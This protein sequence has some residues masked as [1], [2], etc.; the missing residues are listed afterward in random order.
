[1]FYPACLLDPK[2]GLLMLFGLLNPLLLLDCVALPPSDELEYLC[3]IHGRALNLVTRFHSSRNLS[4]VLIS[5]TFN[6]KGFSAN[7]MKGY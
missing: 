6:P 5:M 3:Q 2:V 7:R 4:H 1:M